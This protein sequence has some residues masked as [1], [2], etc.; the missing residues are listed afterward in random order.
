MNADHCSSKLTTKSIEFKINGY[1]FFP[2][3][4]QSKRK[5][6]LEL[7]GSMMLQRWYNV[8]PPW[9]RPR[10]LCLPKVRQRM[11]DLDTTKIIDF[12]QQA[13]L[14]IY[15]MPAPISQQSRIL[16]WIDIGVQG[17]SDW[18]RS[19]IESPV[20]TQN[21][22]DFWCECNGVALPQW[23]FQTWWQQIGWRQ[24]QLF[25]IHSNACWSVW[26]KQVHCLKKHGRLQVFSLSNSQ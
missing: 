17:V 2:I 11:S 22:V 25:T 15:W 8:L 18:R 16:F 4:G 21:R 9:K 10:S 3:L 1:C 14:T 19:W 6:I 23:R 20:R 5:T 26:S 13:R 12:D 7:S 24:T